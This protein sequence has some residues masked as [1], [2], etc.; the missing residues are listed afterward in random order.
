MHT[1]LG[2]A[3]VEW[4]E[5]I[6]LAGVFTGASVAAYLGYFRKA[7]DQPQ[8][9]IELAGA[10][11]DS[12]PVMQLAAALEAHNLEMI[13]ARLDREKERQVGY[14]TIEVGVRLADEIEELRRAVSDVANQIARSK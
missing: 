9:Q 14:R 5:I 6:A 4:N 8:K 12:T 3:K 2:V 10:L 7:P 13:A 1:Q 11:V